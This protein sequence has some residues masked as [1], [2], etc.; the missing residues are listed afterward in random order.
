MISAAGLGTNLWGMAGNGIGSVYSTLPSAWNSNF[1]IPYAGEVF[2][3]Q[4]QQFS[5]DEVKKCAAEVLSE[6]YPY[7]NETDATLLRARMLVNSRKPMSELRDLTLGRSIFKEYEIY[8]GVPNDARLLVIGN[9]QNISPQDPGDT[10]MLS[11]QTTFRHYTT[12]EGLRNIL[13]TE[14]LIPG[15][16]P[17]SY[18][19]IAFPTLMGAFV[20]Y[21]ELAPHEC[22][23][24]NRAGNLHYVDVR[25]P[26]GTGG[27]RLTAKTHEEQDC[28]FYM[29]PGIPMPLREYV[30]AFSFWYTHEKLSKEAARDRSNEARNKMNELGIFT[31]EAQKLVPFVAL[32]DKIALLAGDFETLMMNKGHFPAPSRIPVEVVDFGKAPKSP[33]VAD[34]Q[35]KEFVQTISTR[36]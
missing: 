31:N 21:P 26:S 17:H 12:A 30:L 9:E 6:G 1:L 11:A 36:T 5:T 13:E 3:F 22:G 29:I 14:T 2:A 4:N 10:I 33:F 34:T 24:P 23:V 8:V 7:L 19:N 32:W 35:M 25:F 16:R 27:L 20:L 15:T 28:F 18:H